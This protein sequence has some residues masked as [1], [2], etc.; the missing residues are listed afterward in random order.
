[1]GRLDLAPGASL[2]DLNLQSYCTGGFQYVTQLGSR[3]CRIDQHGN[4]N[5]LRHQLVQKCQPLRT[6]LIRKKIDSRQVATRLGEAGDK[7]ELHRVVADAED[8]RDGRGRSFGHLGGIVAGWRGD[9]G[10]TTTHEV[11]HERRKAIEFALQPMVVHHYVLSLDVARFVEALAERGGKGR[12]RRSGIDEADDRHRWLLRP[13]R[14]RPRG[15]RA[16][17]K[18]DELA[19]LHLR[20]HSITSSAMAS[21]VAGTVRRS[22]RAV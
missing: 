9:D 22:I 16:T 19:P 10:Y 6:Q 21:K 11:S 8:D 15:S 13:R 3:I 17:E 12:I 18:R 4:P 2:E 5:G 7:A 20:G 1:E 14:E